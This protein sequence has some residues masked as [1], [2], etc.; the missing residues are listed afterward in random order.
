MKFSIVIPLYN[1]ALYIKETLQ[2]LVDQTKLPYEIIIVDDKSTD[3]SLHKVKTF[4]KNLPL[5]LK[6]IKVKIIEL[7]KNNGIGYTRNSGFLAATGD[8][9]SFLDADDLYTND[10]IKAANVLMSSY[11]IDF[12]ILG[13]QFFPSNEILPKINKIKNELTQISSVISVTSNAYCINEPLKL[14]TS[15]NFYMGVGSNVMLRRTQ[16]TAISFTE[17]PIIYEGIDY[18]YRVLRSVLTKGNSKVGLLMGAHLKVREVFGSASRKRYNNWREIDYPPV[19]TRFKSSTDYYDKRLKRVVATRWINHAL[20]S[21]NSLNQKI[22][23]I[24]KYRGL[25]FKT[26]P[27]FLMHKL[28]K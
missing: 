2:S 28:K 4:F 27:Y 5:H 9:V 22:I 26:L 21:I 23:F 19:L 6:K 12:L 7:D 11:S 1:K 18:W 10:L 8:V 16:G 24:L 25:F 13:I 15:T 20:L 17:E 3:N 14:I